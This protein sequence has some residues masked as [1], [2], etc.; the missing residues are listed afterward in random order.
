MLSRGERKSYCV[1]RFKSNSDLLGEAPLS[2]PLFDVVT[3]VVAE[4]TI[5]LP[6]LNYDGFTEK[7]GV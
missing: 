2:G 4:V 6:P 1:F 3:K 7:T 5:V